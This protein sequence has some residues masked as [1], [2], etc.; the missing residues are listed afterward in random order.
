AEAVVAK[1]GSNVPGAKGRRISST[2]DGLLNIEPE[3]FETEPK[4][5]CLGN[6]GLAG[7]E[8]PGGFPMKT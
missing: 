1:R 3:L 5:K 7:H 4:K 2:P 6:N 8:R